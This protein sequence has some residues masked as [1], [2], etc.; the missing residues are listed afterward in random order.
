MNT[1][2]IPKKEYAKLKKEASAY[3]KLARIV[4]TPPPRA[5]IKEVIE[6]FRKTGLYTE[7]FLK[8]L[9]D[10]LGRSSHYAKQ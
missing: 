6:D 4:F 7:N 9:E 10:G 3:H 8:D 1:I 2:T 5:P